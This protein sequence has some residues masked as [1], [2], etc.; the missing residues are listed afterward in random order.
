MNIGWGPA[1]TLG[2]MLAFVFFTLGVWAEGWRH[3]V[4]WS[5]LVVGE[6]EDVHCSDK[7]C[8]LLVRRA[9]SSS[10]WVWIP[11]VETVKERVK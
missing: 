10:D 11:P 4:L 5:R 6:V 1:I 3:E 7:G 2:L 8:S 9:D